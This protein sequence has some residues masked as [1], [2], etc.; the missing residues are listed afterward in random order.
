M[1]LLLSL[2]LACSGTDIAVT[3]DT[4]GDTDVPVALEGPPIVINEFLASNDVTYADNAG[5]YDDWVEL[6]NAG[7][8]LVQLDG[9]YLTD[10]V[11]ER[12]KWALPAGQGIDAGGYLLIWCDNDGE[13]LADLT[14][15]DRHANFKLNAAGDSL[16]LYFAEAG[17]EV[18]V[19]A[20][21][22]GAQQPDI[23]G[24]R[25]PDGS[26]TWAYGTPTPNATNR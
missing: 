26:L 21:E 18:R 13:A 3:D 24:A 19:D 4:G 14:Q 15:G 6:Y 17:V 9:L 8:A 5:E 7:D 20:I 10:N 22:F 11:D 1:P 16:F 25:T 12:T 23:S 2:T